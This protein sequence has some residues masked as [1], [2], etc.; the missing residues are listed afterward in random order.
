MCEVW[1]VRYKWRGEPG[2][3]AG[4]GFGGEGSSGGGVPDV[5][6][7]RARCMRMR[8]FSCFFRSTVREGEASRDVVRRSR[9]FNASHPLA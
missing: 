3:G 6:R 1:G 8:W 4:A 7:V 5:R 9:S 2:E